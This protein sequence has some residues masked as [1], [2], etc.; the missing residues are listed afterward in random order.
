MFKKLISPLL[1]LTLLTSCSGMTS[2]VS[3]GDQVISA[4]EIQKIV[5]EVLIS[6]KN[7]DTT[8]MDL[9]VGPQLLRDQAQFF[10]VKVLMNQIAEDMLIT[11][12]PA[13]VAA[14]RVDVITRLG[15]ESE[16]PAALVG[17]NLATSN[18]ESYLRVLIIS[19]RLQ[20]NFVASGVSENEAPI[21][22]EQLVVETAK[23]LKVS[24]NTKY[25]KWNPVK[26]SIEASDATGGAVTDQP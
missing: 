11:V 1:L 20:D 15:A 4:N 9:V 19:E 7:L 25:G 24:V 5:D 6:R 14:R 13:D 17:A 26:A 21:F 10:I 3:V 22:V 18:F 12:S 8:G 23:K 2:G 16:L